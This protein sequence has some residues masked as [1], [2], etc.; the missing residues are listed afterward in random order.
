MITRNNYIPNDP[1]LIDQWHLNNTGQQ[2]GTP[3]ADANV[4]DAW[5]LLD[6][7]GK[8]ILGTGVV[9]GIV[10]DGLEYTH[11]DLSGAYRADLSY[12]FFN[13]DSYPAPGAGDDH[14]TSV[15]GVAAARGNNGTGV[16]GV[17]PN[18]SIAALR[19]T[20]GFTTDQQEAK[21]LSYKPQNI[22]IYSNSWGPFDSG[23]ILQAPGPLTQAAF[24][25]GVTEG[26]GGKGSI[27]VWAG[28]NG[29]ANKDNSNYDGYA[30]SRYTIA[31]AAIDNRDKQS[32]YSEP[33]ANILVAAP[34]SGYSV[35]ITT[36]DRTGSNGYNGLS[37]SDYTN[38]FGGTSSATPLV[39]GVVALMLQA[40]PKLG[41]RDVQKILAV[42][43]R[44]NDPSD[45][46]WV[47]NG[48]G[49]KVNHKY[50][51]GVVDA[52]AAVQTAKT[53]TNLAPEAKYFSGLINV[54]T[55][56][57]DSN[58]QGISNT[59]NVNQNLTI[60]SVEVT[61]NANHPFRGD[62][63][64]SLVTP[65]GT[66]S[67]LAT[68]HF[69]AGANYPNW[70]FST[71]RALNESSIGN[72]TLKVSDR[73]PEDVGTWNSWQLNI[74]GTNNNT[75]L[76]KIS[77]KNVTVV[78]GHTS[79]AIFTVSLNSSVK[80]TIKVNYATA[81]GTA[82]SGSDYIAT[83]GV[84][85]FSPGQTSKTVAV[86]LIDNNLSEV[87]ETF[88][89]NL[90][91]PSNATVINN[92]VI[93]T[94]SDTLAMSVTTT[95]SPTIENLTLT[96]TATING[97]GNNNNNVITGNIANN[98]LSGLWGNDT[99]NGGAGNDSLNGGAG[100]DH[101]NGGAGNDNY[102]FL[103]T[104]VLGTDQIT[105]MTNGGIDNINFSGTSAQV[106]IN[107]GL[108]S[109]QT[110]VVNNLNLK[111]SG[112]N[113]IENAIG[114]NGNDIL[115]GNALNN[116]LIGNSGNDQLNGGAGNDTLN[117]GSGNDSLTGGSGND[118]FVYSTQ[119]PFTATSVGRDTLND[120]AANDRIALSKTT[121]KALASAIGG[122]FS[123]KNEFAVVSYDSQVASSI[124]KIV[125]SSST[126]NIF[127]NENGSAL[128][129]GSGSNF[130]TL[131]TS[132]NISANSFVLVG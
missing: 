60:E 9:I 56:I 132:A 68:E 82:L 95:L 16:A 53:W 128:G 48:A 15:A 79:R 40:N 89:L 64:I 81:N 100:N 92:Q 29:L 77:V 129:L 72:W 80:Q 124:A 6:N 78:E 73:N 87:N 66:I 33:G 90:T 94:I 115:I 47:T 31:V 84:I 55:P 99:L 11:P 117:G 25:K 122:G 36:T 2:G 88:T 125:Y 65:S 54:N 93:G 85:T 43:A 69:D 59:F 4:T 57:P 123:Q 120:F 3:G 112:N 75:V 104:K 102:H 1:L 10:D 45:S 106:A 61:F 131:A 17:A 113:V 114:G 62:L 30:N 96:G 18:A 105:E 97:S 70:T 119:T 121:F 37:D 130:A 19:L 27:Y 14:G 26:R 108:T 21:A 109:L 34:S 39:S 46:G 23:D 67:Q 42:S 74:Y 41:W 49:L 20:A 91:N 127:Y 86:A 58:I 110:P 8:N 24:A 44:K 126:R 35:G 101:L 13:N 22:S 71:V 83:T 118:S 52:A 7:Q 107:L 111:L 38:D 76:G 28:G 12:D 103:A 5:N 51:F 116:A 32:W 63:D 98:I 50:G